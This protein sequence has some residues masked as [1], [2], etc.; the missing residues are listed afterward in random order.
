MSSFS[1]D[2]RSF[3]K[4]SMAGALILLGLKP[5]F[6][7]KLLDETTPEGRLSLYNTHTGERIKVQY[8]NQAGEYDLE[9]LLALNWAL[10]CHHTNE[11]ADMDTQVI[12]YLNMVD[13]EFGGG[14]EIHIVSGFRS[15]EYN[16]MLLERGRGVSKNSLHVQGKAIDFF[17]PRIALDNLRTAALDL[18]YGGV[19]YYPQ[20]GFVHIDSGNFRTW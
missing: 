20:T 13:S 15:E 11:T 7:T 16:E 4:L 19:G 14:N 3:L 10:R 8:R 17:I 18:R 12:E 1:A 2:R 9:A 5:A 6:A